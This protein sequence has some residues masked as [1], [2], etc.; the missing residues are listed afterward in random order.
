MLSICPRHYWA[1]LTSLSIKIKQTVC[2]YMY[3]CPSF[4]CEPPDQFCTDL[5]TH[6]GKVLNTILTPP[7][8]PPDPG[9]PQTPKP[10]QITGHF[11]VKQSFSP[12]EG[13]CKIW[14][15]LVCWFTSERGTQVVMGPGQK[16]LTWVGSGWVNFLWLGSGRVGS[17]IMVW[18]RIRKISP[19]NIKFFNFFPFG[20]K[21]FASGRVRKYPGQSRVGLLFTAG[22]K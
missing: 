15:R 14:W 13:L 20:S 10:K 18:V 11:F 8:W 1:R 2:T 21:K 9:I 4:T 7:T 17:A 5:H 12:C 16:F 3:L 22:Q 6:S 19:K